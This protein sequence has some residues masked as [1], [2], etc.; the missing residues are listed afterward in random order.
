MTTNATPSS[1]PGAQK[2]WNLGK[3]L[4]ILVNVVLLVEIAPLRADAR[5]VDSA[6]RAVSSMKRGWDALRERAE[7]GRQFLDVRRSIMMQKRSYNKTVYVSAKTY[8]GANFFDEWDFYSGQDYTHGYVDYLTKEQAFTKGLAYVTEEGRAN[9]HVDNWTVLTVDDINNGKYR[10]SVRISTTAKYN[11]GLY[12]LDVAKAPFGCSTWPAYWSTNENWPRDGEIDIIENVHASLSNQVSWHTLPGCNL[13]TSGNYTGTALNT[14]CDSNYM[15]NTGCNIVDPSVASF[16]PVF[17]EK[18][19]GV[20]AMK[21]DDKSIDV[22]FFY[23]AAIPDN[24]IQGLPDPTTWPT[25]SASLSSQGCPIDQFFRNHMFI[26]DT[27]LCGDWAGTSYSTSGCPGSCAE[28]VANPSN[29]VNATWSI[30]YLKVYNKTVINTSYLDS[31]ATQGTSS[32]NA[33]TSIYLLL[34]TSLAARL[35]SVAL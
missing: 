21:W 19:G 34:I 13:V 32:T 16:G 11:H 31:S 27:T 9:M 8:Q 33:W 24:I 23:R 20:F 15:S 25:P 26:F 35:L 3:A 10:P 22:W 17:N 2:S 1:T 5:A 28:Q 12:I 30:N 4:F 14:I 7:R 29:F 18:G 6:A